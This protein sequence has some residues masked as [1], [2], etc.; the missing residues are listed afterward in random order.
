M[1]VD[2]GQ[3]VSGHVVKERQVEEAAL[4]PVHLGVG[5]DEMQDGHEQDVSAQEDEQRIVH[6]GSEGVGEEHENEE[7]AQDLEE[8]RQEED[9]S[10]EQSCQVFVQRP[11]LQGRV[12]GGEAP[13]Q[14]QD[15]GDDGYGLEKNN[16]GIRT[17]SRTSLQ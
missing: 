4:L 14:A 6:P 2:V 13:C 3:R 11:S 15:G 5:E 9:W 16:S 10:V 1:D 7:P 12:V 17:M 8:D